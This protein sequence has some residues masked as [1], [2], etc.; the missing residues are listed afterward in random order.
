[1]IIRSKAPLRVSFGGGG[2]DVPPYCDERGGCVLN[3]TIDRYAYA[4][5][6]TNDDNRVY[7]H[8]LDYDTVMEYE[9]SQEIIYDGKL[10]LVKAA[11]KV[12]GVDQGFNL[13]LHSDAPPGS[14]LG[15]SSTLTVALVGLFRHW[16][17]LPLT[18]YDIA[19]YAYRIERLEL[20]ILGGKQDQYASTFGGFNFIEFDR[21]VVIVNPLRIRP[22]IVNE[23]QYRLM[24]CNTGRRRLSAGIIKDQVNGYMHQ[25]KEL[26]HAL[27]TTKK[28]A[29]E[30]KKA[31]LLGRLNA[32]GGLLHEAWIEKRKFSAKVSEAYIDDLYEVARNN[33]AIGGKLLGAGGGGHLLFFCEFN[34]WH[35][36]ADKLEK[37]GGKVI[38]FCFEFDGFQTWEAAE[39]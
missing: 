23:L 19:E 28:L 1:M 13:F 2:T 5:L 8:S 4:T 21:N 22:D 15:T 38:K 3:V 30:M 11:S 10:D 9:V 20:G 26:I 7:V 6:V 24:L 33:G 25:D 16:L 12:L 37:M 29:I 27:D 39:G 31:L 17:K 18:N 14:G 35:K 36:V 32:F 34:K